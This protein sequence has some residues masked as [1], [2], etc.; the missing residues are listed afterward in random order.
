VVEFL[1]DTVLASGYVHLDA[2]PV[3][4]CDPARP[5]EARSATLWAYRARSPDPELEGLVWFDYRDTKSP[6]HPAAVLK[7]YRGVIQTD[8]A[9]GQCVRA[10]RADHALGLLGACTALRGGGG[11]A[12][13]AA[14]G[15]LSGAD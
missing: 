4:V 12:R 3:D 6:V 5:G 13:G 1:R 9:S 11:Q 2:T 15:G 8:G 10:T 14:R 7:E